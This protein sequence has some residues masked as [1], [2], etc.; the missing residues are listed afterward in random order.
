MHLLRGTAGFCNFQQIHPKKGPMKR[1]ETAPALP[2]WVRSN[3]TRRRGDGRRLMTVAPQPEQI[4]QLVIRIFAESGV[5][6][7]TLFDLHEALLIDDGRYVARSY[8]AAGL[9][10][11]WLIDIG[12]IQFYDE[13]GRMIRT[14]NVFKELKSQRIAA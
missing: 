11:M 5:A 8:R 2:V 6:V 12:I 3:N 7:R 1:E 10:A 9:M 14:I 4:R 13:Q